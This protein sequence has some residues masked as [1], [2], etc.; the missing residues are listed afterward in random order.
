MISYFKNRVGTWV[1]LLGALREIN[2]SSKK[3][4]VVENSVLFQQV[5]FHFQMTISDI[6]FLFLF[7]FF[8]LVFKK[9][10]CTKEWRIQSYLL[11]AKGNTIP[12]LHKRKFLQ[13]SSLFSYLPT[14]SYGVWIGAIWPGLMSWQILT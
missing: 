4:A 5:C 12:K 11:F 7:F 6:I 13:K 2:R 3:F 10:H 14:K 9:R 1:R 8:V